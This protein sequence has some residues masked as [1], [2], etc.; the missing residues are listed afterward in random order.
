MSL[1]PPRAL[2]GPRAAREDAVTWRVLPEGRDS[3]AG[4]DDVSGLV[5]E[6]LGFVRGDVNRDGTVDVLDVDAFV[7]AL[8]D[9]GAFAGAYPD[10]DFENADVNADGSV[11]GDDIQPFVQLVLSP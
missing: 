5:R 10:G 11:N 6:L 1:S 4:L 8:V 9:P 3:A 7:L 2:C